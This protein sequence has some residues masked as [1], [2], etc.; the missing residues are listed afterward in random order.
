MVYGTEFDNGTAGAA[1][2]ID[3]NN[4]N[5]Q[6]S[7]LDENV[8]YT[9]TD[10]PGPANL[11]LRIIQDAGAGNTVTWPASVEWEG[12]TAPTI[13][14]GSNAIDIISLYHD[15]TAYYGSFLQDF[16]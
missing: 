16:S 3:W 4:G 1:D 6:R 10:P 12:G 15:G 5:K 14:A 13:S 9:F 8:T 11:V 2:T 7:T